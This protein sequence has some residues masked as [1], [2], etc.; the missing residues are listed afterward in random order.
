MNAVGADFFF[1]LDFFSFFCC[2]D[3]SLMFWDFENSL[4][5]YTRNLLSKYYDK[6]K[7]RYYKYLD[8]ILT[9]KITNLD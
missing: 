4:I 8:S 9:L 7:V 1:Q 3:S 6:D 5:L 2:L